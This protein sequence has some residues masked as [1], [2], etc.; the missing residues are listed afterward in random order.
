MACG[1]NR[2]FWNWSRTRNPH[3]I[4]CIC[5]LTPSLPQ[6]VKFLGWMIHGRAC[7]QCIFWS[8]NVYFQF[9]AFWWR[10]FHMPVWKRRQKGL[11]VSNFAL[12][13][14]VFKWHH[15]SEGVNVHL[16]VYTWWQPE[17]SAVEC[18]NSSER[19]RRECRLPERLGNKNCPHGH[20]HAILSPHEIHLRMNVQ[21]HI[22][23]DPQHVQLGKATTTTV[24]WG[25]EPSQ[26]HRVIWGLVNT[27][28]VS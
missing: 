13:W 28:L 25:F 11:R 17:C 6:P 21:L 12:S 3:P 14:V 2:K 24:R 26:P 18:Y 8:Y 7:K 16:H 19:E 10:S 20:T 5:E 9:Y 1:C 23:S 4:K 22:P 15:G 27:R